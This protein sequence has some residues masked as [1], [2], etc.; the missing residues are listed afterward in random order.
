[1]PYSF[2]L[3]LLLHCMRLVPCKILLLLFPIV[4]GWYPVESCSCDLPITR[5]LHIK[6]PTFAV[7]TLHVLT[8]C[9]LQN[10]SPTG[11]PLHVAL[12]LLNLAFNVLYRDGAT[13]SKVGGLNSR[14]IQAPMLLSQPK[15]CPRYQS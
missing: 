7:F 9:L 3:L 4:C 13:I 10:P 1:M 14:K 15:Q 5:P 6:K 2:F 11:I 12:T 8:P